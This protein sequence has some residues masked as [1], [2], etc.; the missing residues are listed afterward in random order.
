YVLAAVESLKA[1]GV[2]F[3]FTLVEN[4]P[5]SEARAILEKCDILVDQLRIGWYGVLA[6]EGMALGKCVISYVR[7]DLK[8]HLGDTPPIKIANP[9]TIEAAL[10]D[11]IQSQEERMRIARQGHEYCRSIHDP[12][13]V[14]ET[15]KAVYESVMQKESTIDLARYMNL[16]S[17]QESTM[18]RKFA[19][20]V[21][22]SSIQTT[23]KDMTRRWFWRKVYLY[24][25]QH[26]A[27]AL[28]K[29]VKR[30]LAHP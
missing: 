14:A 9:D 8:K 10:L 12:I 30:K 6:V 11:V 19:K 4:M 17:E 27:I 29:R 21:R 5:Q 26:G 1:K 25:K 7:E 16:N 23:S 18:H 20:L 3:D 13:A 22:L 2:E 24:Y 15:C 28:M